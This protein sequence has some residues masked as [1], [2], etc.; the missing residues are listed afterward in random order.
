MNNPKEIKMKLLEELMARMDEK[1]V[2]FLKSKSPKFAKVDVTTNDPSLV[3]KVKES[4]GDEQEK[5]EVFEVDNQSEE[6]NEDLKRLIELWSKLS[7]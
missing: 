6:E 7:K 1:E 5:P 4:L 3:E 2:D